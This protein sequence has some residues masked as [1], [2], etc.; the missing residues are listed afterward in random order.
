MK[1]GKLAETYLDLALKLR[2]I[3]L[4]DVSEVRVVTWQ[5]V[6]VHTPRLCLIS[7]DVA[8]V[9]GGRTVIEMFHVEE[10]LLLAQILPVHA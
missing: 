9:V 1:D 3:V 2:D 6:T 7:R 5:L 10:L 4:D 8:A